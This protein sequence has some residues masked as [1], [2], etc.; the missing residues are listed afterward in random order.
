MIYMLQATYN[1]LV[2]MG[3]YY[4]EN[5]LIW[6]KM[7][8]CDAPLRVILDIQLEQMRL[9]RDLSRAKKGENSSE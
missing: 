3:P 9:E 6:I 1:T 2:S 4:I 8:L 7:A 5:T